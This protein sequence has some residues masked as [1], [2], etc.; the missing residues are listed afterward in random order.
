ML[1]MQDMSKSFGTLRALRAVNLHVRAGEIHGLLGENGAGKTTLMNVLFGLVDP[2]SGTISI[3]GTERQISS[4][5]DAMKFGIGMVHQH[6]QLVPNLSVAENVALGDDGSLFRLDLQGISAK[7]MQLSNKYGLRVDPASLAGSLSVGEQQRVEILKLLYH[8]AEILVFDEPTAVLTPQEWIE[9]AQLLRQLA[10]DGK[11]II[12]ISHKLGEHYAIS[13]RCTV[14]RRG[15]VVGTLEMSSADPD[16]LI[17]MMVG[18]TVST[19][20]R[21]SS[22]MIGETF[23]KV[24]GISATGTHAAVRS[25]D[26][27]HLKLRGGEILAVAGVDGNGQE[28][29]VD[30]LLGVLPI[31]EG[32]IIMM[33]EK[34]DSMTPDLFRKL[35]GAL[36]TANRHATGVAEDLSLSDNLMITKLEGD[37]INR[38]FLRAHA[39][40]D[41]VRDQL[42]SFSV[43]APGPST[44]MAALS[45]GNQQK[46]VL[47]RELNSSA[48]VVIA[49]QPSRGLDVGATELV[50]TLL[51]AH[52]AG[53]GAVLLIS[54]ELD[55]VLALADRIVVMSRGRLVGELENSETLRRDAIGELMAG[56]H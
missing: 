32:S 48:S 44:T 19:P 41:H 16:E 22:G 45:G 26:N 49:A 21:P 51:H 37:L 12:F 55:E 2:D 9:I 3:G 14:L 52:V 43:A 6:F 50:H 46:V 5:R 53:G 28:E 39:V 56:S 13:D 20:T 10:A 36:I 27:V 8:E 38:G 33:G 11:S 24:E 15:E 40:A 47:A 35:G 7:L 31:S 25:L 29:L 1:N 30:A 54:T 4:P 34:H 23:L 18:R 17:E 42:S